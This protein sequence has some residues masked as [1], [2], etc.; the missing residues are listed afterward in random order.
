MAKELSEEELLKLKATES[1]T[2]VYA[3]HNVEDGTVVTQQAQVDVAAMAKEMV[4]Q[5]KE[6]LSKS[7]THLVEEPY[8]QEENDIKQG[9]NKVD[10]A[11]SIMN[12]ATAVFDGSQI[13]STY[14]NVDFKSKE[15][16]DWLS[17]TGYASDAEFERIERSGLVN[18][19]ESGIASVEMKLEDGS[20]VS[21]TMDHLDQMAEN[22]FATFSGHSQTMAEAVTEQFIIEKTMTVGD[23]VIDTVRQTNNIDAAISELQSKIDSRTEAIGNYEQ[24]IQKFD[25]EL[26]EIYHPEQLPNQYTQNAMPN[27]TA[28][29][30]PTAG[31]NPV[32]PSGS[33]NPVPVNTTPINTSPAGS[34]Q[35]G[36]ASVDN[37]MHNAAP[38]GAANNFVQSSNPANNFVQNASPSNMAS[39]FVQNASPANNFAQ[40]FGQNAAPASGG[41]IGHNTPPAGPAPIG[42]FGQNAAEKTLE[43]KIADAQEMIS[44]ARKDIARFQQDLDVMT[45]AKAEGKRAELNYNIKDSDG[46]LLG[47]LD[48]NNFAS[49]QAAFNH[50]GKTFAF[51][52]RDFDPQKTGGLIS[53]EVG[54]VVSKNSVDHNEVLKQ[55]DL[56]KAKVLDKRGFETNESAEHLLSYGANWNTYKERRVEALGKQEVY[57]ASKE[58]HFSSAKTENAKGRALR[59]I[60]NSGY[61]YLSSQKELRSILSGK[62]TGQARLAEI[63]R[64]KSDLTRK[65]SLATQLGDHALIT[66]YS[67]LLGDIKTYE[68]FGGKLTSFS[69][70]NKGM[71]KLQ[72]GSQTLLRL[73]GATQNDVIGG[74]VRTS[75]TVSAVRSVVK[76]GANLVTKSFRDTGASAIRGAD[77]LAGFAQKHA[78]NSL[79]RAIKDKTS[80]G[81]RRA[82]Y[83]ESLHKAR[84]NGNKA[85]IRQLKKNETLRRNSRKAAIADNKAE[86]IAQKLTNPNLSSDKIEKLKN[87]KERLEHRADHKRAKNERIHA[88]DKRKED[89]KTLKDQKSKAKRDRRKER[90]DHSK[91]GKGWNKMTSKINAAKKRL[92]ESKLGKAAAKIKAAAQ[93]VAKAIAEVFD[94]LK[95]FKMAVIGLAIALVIRLIA[96]TMIGTVL[97]NI[98]SHMF[99]NIV[100]GIEVAGNPGEHIN[101]NQY[102]VDKTA[103]SMGSTF[104][105]VASSDAKWHFLVDELFAKYPSCLDHGYNGETSYNGKNYYWAKS[106]DNVSV[107]HIWAREEA[108]N[109][110]HWNA[111]ENEALIYADTYKAPADRQELGSVNINIAPIMAMANFRITGSIHPQNF[112]TT[113]A[114]AYYM[115]IMSHDKSRFADDDG[116]G[117]V[118]DPYDMLDGAEHSFDYSTYWT[119][120]HVREGYSWLNDNSS[121]YA[122]HRCTT[123]S[124]CSNVYFHGYNQK[125]FGTIG[126]VRMFAAKTVNELWTDIKSFA[127]KID[128]N[129]NVGTYE[130]CFLPIGTELCMGSKSSGMYFSGNWKEEGVNDGAMYSRKHING[131]DGTVTDSYSAFVADGTIACDNMK[132]FQWSSVENYSIGNQN[133][134]FQGREPIQRTRN[135][136]D[137]GSECDVQELKPQG[138][139]G[140]TWYATTCGMLEHT[141]GS[142]CVK[143]TDYHI[144][145]VKNDVKSVPQPDGEIVIFGKKF[146]VPRPPKLVPIHTC[147]DKCCGLCEHT[148]SPFVDDSNMGCWTGIAVCQGHC[149][150][151]LDARL[152]IV[153][154]NDWEGLMALDN[155]KMTYFLTEAD[156]TTLLHYDQYLPSLDMWQALWKGK[157]MQWFT[158]FPTTVLTD[159]PI[160]NMIAGSITGD[161]IFHNSNNKILNSDAWKAYSTETNSTGISYIDRSDELFSEEEIAGGSSYHGTIDG[162]MDELE[163]ALDKPASATQSGGREKPEDTV[164]ETTT[165]IGRD[166]ETKYEFNRTVGDYRGTDEEGNPSDNLYPAFTGWYEEQHTETELVMGPDGLHQV[167][168]TVGG[169]EPSVTMME[170]MFGTGKDPDTGV[171][172]QWSDIRLIYGGYED[173]CPKYTDGAYGIAFPVSNDVNNPGTWT[174]RKAAVVFNAFTGQED[175]YRVN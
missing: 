160:G 112:R 131:N 173:E 135:V 100:D 145:E 35:M 34:S 149:G 6:A 111:D 106:I 114:Y 132:V 16:V 55:Y 17:K 105:K 170:V 109:T 39:S 129:D 163:G 31:V 3:D 25:R 130:T 139:T 18:F 82:A 26:T 86:K 33:V 152:N 72:K 76:N 98:Y 127:D 59:Q 62:A 11:L 146:S 81:A 101:L 8:N 61:E 68:K 43:S 45:K 167:T 172:D 65:L 117:E 52:M 54:I 23:T 134:T 2:T 161:S 102:I 168:K 44:D 136:N 41:N 122:L 162:V 147:N 123:Y 37:L 30:Q 99:G 141:H 110:S 151:H 121:D 50:E 140:G 53:K 169:Y 108:D 128:G 107:G 85:E 5:P 1:V 104:F 138:A 12:M 148:H 47:R 24:Q 70:D 96:I 46:K 40:N 124:D 64:A 13:N 154:V 75:Q 92:A 38:S 21:V 77:K 60:N 89:K 116:D 42:S 80:E 69:A 83:S 20:R 14:D 7:V 90:F 91:F 78:D 118:E 174:Y 159:N 144:H 166:G 32:Q 171:Y 28:N 4:E 74:Y 15:A 58:M 88:R 84:M 97:G 73:S 125:N 126:G 165:V 133:C 143:N 49:G 150:G 29:I 158:P 66:R 79:T 9:K 157:A 153:V 19:N 156:F 56:S 120:E 119:T 67:E 71:Q 142:G 51:T 164:L 94:V 22:G 103:F 155:F 63:Q 93:K 48:S 36:Q 95:K 87:K 175:K 115:F 113:E 27:P 10:D 57:N 137:S